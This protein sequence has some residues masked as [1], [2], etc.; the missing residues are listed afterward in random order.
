MIKF[1][2]NYLQSRISHTL[3]Q[4]QVQLGSSLLNSIVI[5]PSV[6]AT[7]YTYYEDPTDYAKGFNGGVCGFTKEVR[8]MKSEFWIKQNNQAIDVN[9]PSCY[10]YAKC[11]TQEYADAWA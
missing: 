11:A 3:V 7:N 1:D 4:V 2:E 10:G 6:E 8:E 9:F 5:Y